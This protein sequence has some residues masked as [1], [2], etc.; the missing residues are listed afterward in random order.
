MAHKEDAARKARLKATADAAALKTALTPT[1]MPSIQDAQVA[2]SNLAAQR[3]VKK[4]K[5]FKST[6]LTGLH[7]GLAGPIATA[8]DAPS[9]AATSRPSGWPEWLRLPADN[10]D[11][12]GGAGG[13]FMRRRRN[14]R[15]R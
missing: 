12:M 14:E 10:D 3:A 6:I 11:W 8:L 13:A 5:G 1:A 9:G 2:K 4:R 15:R 7:G